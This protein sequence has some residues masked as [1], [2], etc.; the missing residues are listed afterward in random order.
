MSNEA[1][2]AT[3]L[4]KNAN[5]LAWVKE[6]AA[7]T[8]PDQVVWCDGSEDEKRRLTELAVSDGTLLPLN[9]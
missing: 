4:T 1:T 8:K 5:L 7:L 6:I 3:T 9:Q 2:T